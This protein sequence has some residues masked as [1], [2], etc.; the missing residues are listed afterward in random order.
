MRPNILLTATWIM[1]SAWAVPASAGT[2]QA[3]FAVR[4]NLINPTFVTPPSVPAPPSA[5]YCISQTLGQSTNAI[6]KVV[7]GSNEFVSISPPSGAPFGVGT[8]GGAYRFLFAPGVP[9]S[10]DDPLWH[11]GLGTVTTARIL[12]EDGKEETMEILVSF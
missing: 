2:A 10:R 12:R 9:V 5:G 11:M 3:A 8:H 6:V 7:C 4:V 1:L